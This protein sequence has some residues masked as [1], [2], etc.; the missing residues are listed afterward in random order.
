LPLYRG[1]L[2]TNYRII[3]EPSEYCPINIDKRGHYKIERIVF[4]EVSNQQQKRRVKA[5]LLNINNLCGHTTNYCFYK[6]QNYNNFIILGLLNSTLINYYFSYF[7]N[8]NHIPI[9]EIKNIP[10]AELNERT[11]DILEKLVLQMLAARKELH[12]ST[13]TESGA[14]FLQQKVDAIDRQIDRLVYDLY[15]LTEEEIKI[16]EGK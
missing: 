13:I 1:N 5:A 8:T 12:A 6:N 2:I 4:Q 11:K 10:V 16:V 9:G 3:T 15:G 7:N 14:K